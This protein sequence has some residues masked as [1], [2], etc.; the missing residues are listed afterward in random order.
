MIS[1]KNKDTGRDL[2]T[3]GEDDLQFLQ[4]QMEEESDED[5]DYYVSKA[6]LAVL[7]EQGADRELVRILTDAI[8]TGD[9]VEISWAEV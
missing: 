7:K 3:I 9:G 1:I 4:D 8:G 5:T 6:M 2:G